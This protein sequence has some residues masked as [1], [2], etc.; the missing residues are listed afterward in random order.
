MS[1][2]EGMFDIEGYTIDADIHESE[3]TYG[4]FLY[5][6]NVTCPECGGRHANYIRRLKEVGWSVAYLGCPMCGFGVW[7]R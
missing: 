1:E 6:G 3:C 5:A 7:L 2:E 4:R